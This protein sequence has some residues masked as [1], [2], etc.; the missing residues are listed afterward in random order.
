MRD[1]PPHGRVILALDGHDGGGKTTIARRLAEEIG[2][3]YVRPFGGP[4][5]QKLLDDAAAGRFGEVS[6]AGKE[7]VLAQEAARRDVLVFDR[8]W[9]T[10]FTLVGEEWWREWMPIPPTLLCWASLDTTLQ[11]LGARGED[12]TH[13]DEHAHYIDAY[14]GLAQRFGCEVIRTD[15]YSEDES[16]ALALSWAKNVM[17]AIGAARA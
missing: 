5:G 3:A 9:M 14:A 2:A 15:R 10:I 7:M 8:H 16:L 1:S 6:R 17:T 13:V 12:V 4:G 11:R